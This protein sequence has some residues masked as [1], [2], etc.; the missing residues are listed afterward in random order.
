MSSD[1]ISDFDDEVIDLTKQAEPSNCPSYQ[2]VQV[3]N[4]LSMMEKWIQAKR[5]L[6]MK[7]REQRTLTLKVPGLPV[8][9]SPKNTQ[10]FNPLTLR[11]SPFHSIHD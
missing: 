3:P 8:C 5:Q 10:R 4:N 7:I 1:D 11:K 9:T 6:A 2:P